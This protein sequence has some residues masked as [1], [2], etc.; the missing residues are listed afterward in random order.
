MNKPR[1]GTIYLVQV[2][3]LGV[4]FP[5]NVPTSSFTVAVVAKLQLNDKLY[6]LIAKHYVSVGA[7]IALTS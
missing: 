6:D 5:S 1:Q 7:K 2:R 4:R 3:H